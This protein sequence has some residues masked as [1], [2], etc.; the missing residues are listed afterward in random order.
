MIGVRPGCDLDRLVQAVELRQE[1]EREVLN[2]EWEA[3]QDQVRCG[4]AE[5]RERRLRQSLDRLSEPAFLE[6]TF[7]VFESV[8]LLPE[9]V[10]PS[11][12]SS[13]EPV[14]PNQAEPIPERYLLEPKPLNAKTWLD[15]EPEGFT[16]K[17]ARF[18]YGDPT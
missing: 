13:P 11:F 7:P 10:Q 16:R 5:E 2:R 4:Y 8:P 3:R 6:P 18:P 9:P 1:R 14:F 15:D 17:P 12:D